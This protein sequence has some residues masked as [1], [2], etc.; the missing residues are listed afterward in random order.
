MFL[1]DEERSETIWA[2]RFCMMCQVADRVGEVVMNESY[3]PRGRGAII[4]ALEKGLLKWDEEIADIMF[5]T[6]NDGRL[7]KW[8]VGNYDHEELII[9]TREKLFQKGLLP[10]RI[11]QLFLEEKR[12]TFNHEPLISMIKKSG[13]TINKSS[14]I[15]IYIGYNPTLENY[16]TIAKF[17]NILNFA[18]IQFKILFEEPISGH[19]YYQG[20]DFESAS[21]ASKKIAETIQN[22]NVSKVIVLEA[23]CYRMFTT[24]T[25]RFGGN[26]AG[27]SFEHFIVTLN[28]LLEKKLIR[29]TKPYDGLTVTYQD[30]C[31]LARYCGL[32]VDPRKILTTIGTK[33]IEMDPSGKTAFCCGSGGLLPIHQPD[34]AIEIARKR[35]R[36]AFETRAEYLVT[37]CFGCHKMLSV[38]LEKEN[39]PDS[40]KISHIIDLVAES[41]EL[42]K[43][44]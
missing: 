43:T 36:E 14:E 9:D 24:R 6:L 19:D 4:C 34:I 40:P 5:T 37:A 44:V 41:I 29:V 17:A 30:P 33:L 20:G 39:N 8:C 25:K 28:N 38:G 18:N 12:K 7:Q 35:C 21:I 16:N 23:D 26:I 22:E 15:L 13:I 2:C 3:T 1:N 32:T 11:R 10:E 31:M 42:K 27:I